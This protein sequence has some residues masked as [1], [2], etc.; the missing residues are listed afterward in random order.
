[1][2]QQRWLKSTA[3]EKYAPYA[4]CSSAPPGMVLIAARRAAM[5]SSSDVMPVPFLHV[6]IQPP[7]Y[8][9]PVFKSKTAADSFR[10]KRTVPST[11]A[12]TPHY[13]STNEA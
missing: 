5:A 6:L 4:W 3:A 13:N 8:T 10:R 2:A 11:E 1:M 9:I 12:S 7:D